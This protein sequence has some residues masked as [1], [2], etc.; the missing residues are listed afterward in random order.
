MLYVDIEERGDD[1]LRGNKF[2]IEGKIFSLFLSFF[3]SY[4]F[5]TRDFFFE[6]G[7]K[8]AVRVGYRFLVCS[9][10]EARKSLEREA[11]GGLLSSPLAEFASRNFFFPDVYDR[12]RTV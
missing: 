3:F 12:E 1:T 11:D 7:K 5:R 10:F 6:E 9:S 8:G 2:S 4:D